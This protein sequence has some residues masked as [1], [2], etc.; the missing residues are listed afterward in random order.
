MSIAKFQLLNFSHKFSVAK[1]QSQNFSR[2]FHS[3]TRSL[4]QSVTQ[5][6][7]H[8]LN[9]VGT[10]NFFTNPSDG[11]T[12]QRL[13][14]L[15]R[16]LELLRATKN[17]EKYLNSGWRLGSG[18]AESRGSQPSRNDTLCGALLPSLPTGSLRSL[19]HRGRQLALVDTRVFHNV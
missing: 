10:G 18:V 5:S 17:P 14:R 15:A 7:T 19:C 9:T 1:F 8:S 11:R 2:K 12:D 6:F 4:G 3:V 13:A 16:L